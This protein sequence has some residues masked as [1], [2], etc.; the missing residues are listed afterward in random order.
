MDRKQALR[1]LVNNQGF[2]LE[3]GPSHSPVFSR[4]DGFNVET[5]DHADAPALRAKYAELGVDVSSIE[6]VTYVSDGRPIHEVIPRRG[7]YDFIFSSHTIEH[8]TDLVGYFQSCELLLKPEGIAALAIP[9]KRYTFDVL[10]PVSTTGQAIEAHRQ[11]SGRHSPAAIFDFYSNHG[12]LDG[13]EV[14]TKFHRGQFSLTNAP[15]PAKAQFDLAVSSERYM[16]AHGWCFTPN[17]FRLIM[18]DLKEIGLTDFREIYMME[19]HGLEFHVALSRDHPGNG[20]TRMQI[21]KNIIR[22][23]VLSGA[24][25]LAAEDEAFAELYQRICAPFL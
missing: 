7:E 21:Q 10:R 11:S 8:V 16:D 1:T 24:Q 2:G 20:M 23:N 22:E 6:D 9:D 13:S 19:Q 25:M 4:A 15:G 17:S 5:L 12:K 14:W 3:I 18:H